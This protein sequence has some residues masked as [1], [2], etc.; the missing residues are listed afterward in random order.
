MNKAQ[1]SERKMIYSVATVLLFFIFIYF[2]FIYFFKEMSLIIASFLIQSVCVPVPS[3][4]EDKVLWIRYGL[5]DMRYVFSDHFL[6]APNCFSN[7]KT[8]QI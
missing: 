6:L 1:C 8:K 3:P 5:H 2:N 4:R 7:N